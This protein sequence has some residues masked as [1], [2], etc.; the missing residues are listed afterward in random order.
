MLTGYVDD[1]GS[2]DSDYSGRGR[3]NHRGRRGNPRGRG[4]RGNR[5]RGQSYSRDEEYK[6]VP[7][8]SVSAP[9]EIIAE[10]NWDDESFVMPG[11]TEPNE[12]EISGNEL[13]N[14]HHDE[15]ENYVDEE[16]SANVDDNYS[17][18]NHNTDENLENYEDNSNSEIVVKEEDNLIIT[19]PT[20]EKNRN[21]EVRF[22]LPQSDMEN[23]KLNDYSSEGDYKRKE[24]DL[25][26]HGDNSALGQTE[27]K[28]KNNTVV[29]SD[30]ADDLS[31]LEIKSEMIYEPDV[32]ENVS[33]LNLET[34]LASVEEI[35]KETI[36]DS[37]FQNIK[38][39]SA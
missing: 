27:H 4:H 9:S 17:N 30:V 29:V 26:L 10:E 35:E 2:S 34:S 7:I 20:E 32:N 36:A 13:E 12:L 1:Y 31:N 28:I 22:S 6:A 33:E 19:Y 16:T 38:D 15:F 37:K 39:A 3:G 23:P 14:L 25:D 8:S 24:E 5:G 18:I 11:S 21:R